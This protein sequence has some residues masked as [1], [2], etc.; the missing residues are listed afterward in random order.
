MEYTITIAITNMLFT[1]HI[2]TIPITNVLFNNIENQINSTLPHYYK[3]RNR[4]FLTHYYE[5]LKLTIT[6]LQNLH[7]SKI[8]ITFLRGSLRKTQISENI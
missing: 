8:A 3:I 5:I 7:F 4:V 2:I 6:L 1:K